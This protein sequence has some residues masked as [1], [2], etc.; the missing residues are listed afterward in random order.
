MLQRT[1][2]HLRAAL[3]RDEPAVQLQVPKDGSQDSLPASR[4][5]RN[6]IRLQTP[7]RR[8]MLHVPLRICASLSPRLPVRRRHRR[9]QTSRLLHLHVLQLPSSVPRLRLGT[10]SLATALARRRLQE[11]LRQEVARPD[12]ALIRNIS[13]RTR[14]SNHGQYQTL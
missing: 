6:S 1:F 8:K 11:G 5:R 12:P 4:P 2:H 13:R 3:L 14:P 9:D 7:R 10:E